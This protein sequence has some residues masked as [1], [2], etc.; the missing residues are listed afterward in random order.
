MGGQHAYMM[1]SQKIRRGDA[2]MHHTESRASIYLKR[3]YFARR[4]LL[5]FIRYATRL[6]LEDLQPRTSPRISTSLINSPLN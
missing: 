3:Q 1:S 4:S 6:I 2:T 5:T